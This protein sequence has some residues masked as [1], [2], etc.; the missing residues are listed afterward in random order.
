MLLPGLAVFLAP[1]FL[2]LRQSQLDLSFFSFYFLNSGRPLYSMCSIGPPRRNTYLEWASDSYLLVEGQSTFLY[3]AS[4]SSKVSN[5]VLFARTLRTSFFLVDGDYSERVLRA[6]NA[7]RCRVLWLPKQRLPPAATSNRLPGTKLPPLILL[8][9]YKGKIV[10]Q[11]G[12]STYFVCTSSTIQSA[13]G[14]FLVSTRPAC[15]SYLYC[16][17]LSGSPKWAHFRRG[18]F[19]TLLKESEPFVYF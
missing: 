19:L 13:P 12:Q 1:N 9:S 14:A 4:Y 15:C 8:L 18:S 6:S 3:L 17:C 11:S 7:P 16:P 5:R 10:S 2:I